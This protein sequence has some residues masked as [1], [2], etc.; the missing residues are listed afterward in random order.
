M[1]TNNKTPNL[2]LNAWLGTDKP[3]RSDFVSDNTI[4]DTVLGEHIANTVYHLS[5]SDRAKLEAPFTVGSF[6][7]SGNSTTTVSLPFAPSII[8][9]YK[10]TAPLMQYDSEND[11]TVVNAAIATSSYSSSSGIAV[12]G[13]TLTVNQTQ[14]APSDGVFLN[15]GAQN[16]QYTYI[17]FK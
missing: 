3:M 4:I 13:S 17:A 10:R 14:T 11:Y 9:V 15:L 2:E 5:A 8:V 16:S 7:G 6:T 12:S 1:P